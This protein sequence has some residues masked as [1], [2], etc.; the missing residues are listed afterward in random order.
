LLASWL[1][2]T[3]TCWFINTVWHFGWIYPLWSVWMAW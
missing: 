3:L 2:N 1:A